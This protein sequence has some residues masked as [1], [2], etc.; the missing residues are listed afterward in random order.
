M[1]VPR[2][3]CD[4]HLVCECQELWP[5]GRQLLAQTSASAASF[6]SQLTLEKRNC[7][8]LGQGGP[9]TFLGRLWTCRTGCTVSAVPDMFA[10]E[11]DPPSCLRLKG[12]DHEDKLP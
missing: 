11:N 3:G 5:S 9:W 8:R 4:D 10:L 2:A 12:S 1:V 6:R 7:F